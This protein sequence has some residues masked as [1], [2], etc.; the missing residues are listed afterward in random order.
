MAP[1]IQFLGDTVLI[2]TDGNSKTHNK[3][4][5]IIHQLQD[6]T[7]AHI[8]GQIEI[9][10]IK[11]YTADVLI[12]PPGQAEKILTK[13]KPKLAILTSSTLERARELHKKTGIQV[14][15]AK[16]NLVVDLYTYSALS[17]QKN[18]SKFTEEK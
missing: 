17:E 8:T 3:K 5:G 12:L 4:A 10:E 9:K 15:T 13:I 18:L 16:D 2:K 7:I 1:K 14:I 6:C 11:E